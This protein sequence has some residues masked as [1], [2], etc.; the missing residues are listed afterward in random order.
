MRLSAKHN[1]IEVSSVHSPGFRRN[2]SQPEYSEQREGKGV[3]WAAMII[4]AIIGAVIGG[5]GGFFYYRFIGCHSG[6]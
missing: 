5:A 3:C 2:R 1:A 6:G 4:K